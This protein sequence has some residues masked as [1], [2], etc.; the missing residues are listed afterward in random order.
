MNIKCAY[1]IASKVAQSSSQKYTF[2]MN[3]TYNSQI[4][5]TTIMRYVISHQ[6]LNISILLIVKVYPMLQ[7]TNFQHTISINDIYTW[8]FSNYN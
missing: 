2:Y 7:G 3:N 5:Q 1:I 8:M 4:T 6:R